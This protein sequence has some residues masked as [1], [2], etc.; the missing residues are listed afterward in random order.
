[1]SPIAMA[2]IGFFIG[3]TTLLKVISFGQIELSSE[4]FFYLFINFN[5]KCL[6]ESKAAP[7]IYINLITKIFNC[8]KY[9]GIFLSLLLGVLLISLGLASLVASK[10]LCFM[11]ALLMINKGVAIC[12]A[13]LGISSGAFL[14]SATACAGVLI[15][16]S[17]FGVR[18]CNAAM[19]NALKKAGSQFCNRPSPMPPGPA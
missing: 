14:G 13:S 1:M 17:V 4:S 10:G 8:S 19:D 15:S 6:V 7:I 3:I 5:G 12:A 2:A 18:R 11:P 9:L 16:A